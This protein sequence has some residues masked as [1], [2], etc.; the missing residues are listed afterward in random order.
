[1]NSATVQW[2]GNVHGVSYSTSNPPGLPCT[3]TYNG[4]T[5]RPSDVGTYNVVAT[6][7]DANYKGSGSGTLTITP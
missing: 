3:V 2:D 6:V 4:S 5:S 1:V 7:N